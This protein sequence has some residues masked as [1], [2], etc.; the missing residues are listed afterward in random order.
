MRAVGN[1]WR[2]EGVDPCRGRVLEFMQRDACYS[3]LDI[4]TRVGS[5]RLTRMVAVDPS[6]IW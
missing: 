4:V 1:Q 3:S 6:G 2:W 5:C